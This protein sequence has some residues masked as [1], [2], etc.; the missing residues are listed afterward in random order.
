LSVLDIPTAEVFE[1]LL[2]GS[3]YKAAHGGRGSGKSHFFAGL[4]I[5]R[6]FAE[7]GFRAVC[8]REVQKD[9]SESAKRLL[10]DKISDFG[11]SAHFDCQRAQIVT[12]GG[13]V[14][15]F[16]GMQDHNAESIKSLEGFDVA[17]VEEAQTLSKTSLSMLRPTIRKSGSELW[18]SWN[19]RR[20]NDAVD[21]F[22]RGP[23]GKPAKAIVV[24]AN[25]SDNPWFPQELEDERLEDEDKRPEECE[26]IWGGGYKKVTEGAYYAQD[27]LMA[28]RKGRIGSVSFDP[29]LRVRVFCDL[30]GTGMKADNFTMWP[31]QFVGTQ[32]RMRDYYEAQGQPL[33]THIGWLHS[34]GLTPQR[35]D[36]VLPHDGETNDRVF[37]VSF[38][39][40]FRAAGYA[41]IVIPNQGKGAARM[42]I[43]AGHRVFPNIH[44]D[45]GTTEAGRDALGAYHE[46]KDEAR[47][48]GL[49]P[50]HDWA[51]HGADSFGMAC[52][53]YEKLSLIFDGHDEDDDYDNRQQ[54]RSSTTGY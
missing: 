17:W 10:E 3:R 50:E 37:D 1:P 4:M 12:P 19:P 39:S 41:V 13:G 8:V 30:G 6:A 25:W 11:L 18:F 9:L 38:E 49:G 47:N 52:I 54:S 29:L 31:T 16:E 43:E 24:E 33:A 36:I 34:V 40:A 27:L 32:V 22:F 51:S 46:R 21:D 15:I 7:P 45:E 53:A 14:I 35:A 48:T 26:H 23:A 42:R 20:K 2:Q 5:E 28:K 44:F